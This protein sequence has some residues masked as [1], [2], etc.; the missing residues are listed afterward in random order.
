MGE[1]VKEHIKTIH[2]MMQRTKNTGRTGEGEE[3]QEEKE[4]EL[5]MS[6]ESWKVR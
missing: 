1:A 3:K 2:Q 4:E 5:Y 6:E